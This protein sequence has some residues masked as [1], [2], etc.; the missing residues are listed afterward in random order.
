MISPSNSHPGLTRPGPDDLPPGIP[1]QPEVFYPTGV[2]NY[3]RLAPRDDLQGPA[4]ALLAKQLGLESVYLLHDGDYWQGVLGHSFPPAARRLGL[5]VAGMEAIDP[6]AKS[7]DALA[8][9]VAE[10]G[11]Q[12]VV[13]GAWWYQGGDRVLKALR[14]RLG[15]RVPIITGDGFVPIPDVLEEVGRAAQGLYMT[16][17]ILPPDERLT[18]ELGAT[19]N[20]DFVLQAAEAAEVVLKAI[21]GSDGSRASVLEELRAVEVKEGLVGDF[22]FDRYGDIIPPKLTILRVTGTTPPGDRL[23][24]LYRGATIDRV[25]T[26][27]ASLAD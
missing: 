16:A 12:G 17:L 21:A 2:R 5:R 22:H 27:P 10:S 3:V 25:V 13:L 9:K 20:E 8:D 14:A 18:S 15:E 11:A 4:Q 6:D 1:G 23:P 26:V 19:A 24:A 7:Y